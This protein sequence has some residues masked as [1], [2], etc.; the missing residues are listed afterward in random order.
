M[1]ATTI[2]IS[3]QQ[4]D[5]L[6]ELVR[7]HLGSAGD[8]CDRWSRRRTSARPSSSAWSSAK[9]FELMED[10]GWGED[11]GRESFELTM[12]LHDL[13][14][15]LNRLHG[16]AEVVLAGANP[17]PE[18][19]HRFRH[20]LSSALAELEIPV[21]VLLLTGQEHRSSRFAEME[22]AL[23]VWSRGPHI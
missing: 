20:V 22:K 4:R 8:L 3:S 2:T 1:P 19:A 23:L 21:S 6:Y 7:N 16:E 18:E 14:E 15:V 17:S 10:I 13:T 9:T 12:P 11:E 5:G